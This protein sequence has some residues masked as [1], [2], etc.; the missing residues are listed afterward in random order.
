MYNINKE[1]KDKIEKSV[2]DAYYYYGIEDYHDT[3]DFSKGVENYFD[4][5]VEFINRR[6]EIFVYTDGICET[7]TLPRG[8]EGRTVLLE[9]IYAAIDILAFKATNY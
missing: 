3:I 7:I 2:L 8:N 5:I 6:I 1:L 9:R 4:V